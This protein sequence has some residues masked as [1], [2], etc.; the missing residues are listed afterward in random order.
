L[1]LE[2]CGPW[3]AGTPVDAV[4]TID[5]EGQILF[6]ND[7]AEEVFGYS[8]SEMLRL[9]VAILAPCFSLPESP[10]P[11]QT[12]EFVGRRKDGLLFPLEASFGK[13][14][15]AG[16]TFATGVLRAY[17]HPADKAGEDLREANA[18]LHALFE[19]TP[20]AII[21]F[22]FSEVVLHWNAA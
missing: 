4:L 13:F 1:L 2:N 5:R 22:D 17:T 7:A 19:A 12:Q 10:D 11:N 21:A 6:V 14:Q 20:V 9:N 8:R 15:Q 3:R 18:R 16:Q